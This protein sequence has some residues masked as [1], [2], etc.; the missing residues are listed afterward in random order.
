ML[1]LLE[2]GASRLGIRP[3]LRS[4]ALQNRRRNSLG[5]SIANLDLPGELRTSR[6][7]RLFA[8]QKD[9]ASHSS[10]FTMCM[11]SWSEFSPGVTASLRSGCCSERSLHRGRPPSAGSHQC[12]TVPLCR[13]RCVF[14]FRI[15]DLGLTP[16]CQAGLHDD[17]AA[18]PSTDPS[19][20]ERAVPFCGGSLW[21]RSARTDGEARRWRDP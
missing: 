14:A 10:A 9:V 7:D 17:Q 15:D 19:D 18:L 16:A 3:A 21:R 20:V 1:R 6:Q 13:Y 8:R 2:E 11:T 12:P 4:A 5:D